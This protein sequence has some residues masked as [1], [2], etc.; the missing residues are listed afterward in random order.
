MVVAMVTNAVVAM[1]DVM[2]AAVVNVRVAL[3]YDMAVCKVDMA[4]VI[5]GVMAAA[6]GIV[7]KDYI[8]LAMADVIAV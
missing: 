1:A 5:A 4:A 2:A 8:S 7:A 3:Y 6:M